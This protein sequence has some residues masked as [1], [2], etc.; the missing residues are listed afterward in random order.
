MRSPFGEIINGVPTM[1]R[2]QAGK[3]AILGATGASG[4][5]I[6]RALQARD[7][8]YRV[9]GRNRAE[10]EAAYGHDPLAEIVTWN[11]DDPQSVRDA[12]LGIDTVVQC[13]G[14][15]YDRNGEYPDIT[16][17][18]IDGAIAAGARRY[19]LIGTVYPYGRPQTTPVTESHPR[20]ATTFKG[21]MRKA[22][23]D[24]VLR[25][26]TSGK[27]AATIL[28]L[29]DFYGPDCGK[30]SFLHLAFE[31]AEKGGTADLIGPIDTPHEFVFVPDVGPVVIDLAAKPEA[32]GTWWNFAGAGVT[33]Q[34]QLVDAIFARAGRTPKV[35]VLNKLALRALGLFVPLL[36]EFVEMHY[37]QTTPVL[38]DDTA[39]QRLI[40][41]I[42]KTAYAEGIALTA[43]AMRAPSARDLRAA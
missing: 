43:D 30:A 4:K 24:I 37:L 6:A 33:T 13:I 9:V 34:R 23:E 41:P 25:A 39:L 17:R 21:R 10:L 1:E 5:S 26:H 16:Q 19:V 12:A 11:L 35:R 22:Q 7:L 31:A 8:A 20:A 3:I 42:R 2:T 18:A 38:L 15:P 27:I 40:G 14:V 32:Y 36:R 28:R 29:P